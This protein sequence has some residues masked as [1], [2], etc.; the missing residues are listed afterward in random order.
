MAKKRT[1]ANNGMGSIRQRP[2]GRWEA[3]YTTPDGRQRSVYAKTEK[4]VTAKL[5]G[6]LHDLDSGAWREP[7][8][9]TVGEWLD[10]WLEDYQDDNTERTVLKYKSIINHNFKPV[11]GDF[12]ISKLSQIHIRRMLS[13]MKERGLSQITISN[14]YRI[15]RSALKRATES[16]LIKDNPAQTIIVSRGKAKKFDFIDKEQFPAFIEAASHTKYENELVF[17]LY[18]GLRIGELRGLRWSDVDFEKGTISIERQLH[19]KSHSIERITAPKYLEDRIIHVPKEAIDVLNAQ[20]RKQVEQRLA[21]GTEWQDDEISHDLVF[22]QKD[23]KAH[24]E[25]TIFTAVKRAGNEIGIPDLHPHDLRHSYA[26]AALRSGADVK[27]V[28]H[29]M[30]HKKASMTLDV[31]MAYTED[32]GKDSAVKLSKYLQNKAD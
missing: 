26:I 1:R 5:R 4:E 31:Y 15:L 12:K 3:R 29:N 17:M 2:D 8:K 7:S 19:P 22:R 11:L 21:A 30:G 32:A 24:G 27:T 16:K 28:Q 18:T 25:R 6:Q 13:N 10:I 14:Y 23:G 20:R 9:M